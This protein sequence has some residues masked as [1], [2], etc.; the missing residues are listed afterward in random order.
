MRQSHRLHTSKLKNQSHRFATGEIL[1]NLDADNFLGASFCEQ[2]SSLEPHQF[3]HAWSGNWTD[4][5]CGRLAYHR[6][7]FEAFG[8]YDESLGPAGYDDLDLRDR[9]VAGGAQCVLVTDSGVYGGSV[10]NTR[11]QAVQFMQVTSWDACNSQNAAQSQRYIQHSQL[12]AN[13]T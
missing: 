2:A 6:Q 9:L 1:V 11:V 8:G 3:L 10:V 12:V 13:Q 7:L 4:G 5:T